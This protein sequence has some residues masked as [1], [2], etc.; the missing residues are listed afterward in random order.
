[1]I[2]MMNQV[3]VWRILEETQREQW[4]EVIRKHLSLPNPKTIIDVKK[5]WVKLSVNMETGAASHVML[6]TWVPT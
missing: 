2:T 5:G 6:D 1:M 3:H 4:Q